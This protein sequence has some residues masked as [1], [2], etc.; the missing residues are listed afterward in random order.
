MVEAPLPYLVA[1]LYP[2]VTDSSRFRKWLTTEVVEST[3]T[4]ASLSPTYPLSR[5]FEG[6][7]LP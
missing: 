1:S 5:S 6:T 3:T 2:N 7:T 4:L